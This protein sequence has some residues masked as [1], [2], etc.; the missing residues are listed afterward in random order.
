MSK[1]KPDVSS[2]PVAV[3]SLPPSPVVAGE[4]P[5]ASVQVISIGGPPP[6]AP[7]NTGETADAK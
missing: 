6:R 2:E 5:A 1:P 7:V 3:E 4:S